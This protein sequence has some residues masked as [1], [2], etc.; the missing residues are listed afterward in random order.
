MSPYS[1]SE[2]LSQVQHESSFDTIDRTNA[3]RGERSS[4]QIDPRDFN[5]NNSI[6]V[7]QRQP[8][9]T[10][11]TPNLIDSEPPALDNETPA[12]QKKPV[13]LFMDDD[14]DN[15]SNDFNIFDD[16]NANSVAGKRPSNASHPNQAQKRSNERRKNP[17]NLFAEDDTD[18]FETMLPS[19]SK[20]VS[21]IMQRKVNSKITNLFEDD[22][23]D[24]NDDESD[25]FMKTAASTI[26]SNASL[27]KDVFMCNLFDDEPP[28]DDSDVFRT[29]SKPAAKAKVEDVRENQNPLN[30]DE[31]INSERVGSTKPKGRINLFDDQPPDDDFDVFKSSSKPAVDVIAKNF[32]A[33]DP[34]VT[35]E[36]KVGTNI[37]KSIN[38]FDDE[39]PVDF[40]VFKS[41]ANTEKPKSKVIVKSSAPPEDDYGIFKSTSTMATTETK[42]TEPKLIAAVD[43]RVATKKAA[44]KV[45]SKI[46]LFDD[47]YDDDDI[48][49]G[50]T[51]LSSQPKPISNE[52]K[53]EPKSA[54][55]TKGLWDSDEEVPIE[56]KPSKSNV[57]IFT[58]PN[59]PYDV[60]RLFDDTP[61][62]DDEDLFASKPTK[63][64]AVTIISKARGEFYNDFL[65]TIVVKPDEASTKI[66]DLTIENEIRQEALAEEAPSKQVLPEQSISKKASTE[67]ESRMEHLAQENKPSAIAKKIDLLTKSA[68]SDESKSEIESAARP[69]PK[70]LSVG[71]IEINVAALLPGAKRTKTAEQH[72]EPGISSESEID[73]N[74]PHKPVEI[75][76]V[77]TSTTTT[78]S[79][80]N[81]DDTGR[82]TNL[83]RD[84]AKVVVNRRPS[85]RR[86]RQQQ[87]Q[88]TLDESESVDSVD[89][90]SE[91]SIPA[92]EVFEPKY[93]EEKDLVSKQ[94]NKL[95]QTKSLEEI[96]DDKLM[97][98]K[99][100]AEKIA[101]ELPPEVVQENVDT[102]P[103]LVDVEI[104]TEPLDDYVGATASYTL[105][106]ATVNTN[107][108]AETHESNVA[109]Q[110]TSKS[111]LDTSIFDDDLGNNDSDIFVKIPAKTKMAVPIKVTP[112]FIADLP[113]DLDPAD[114]STFS[115]KNNQNA[116]LLSKNAVDLFD[117]DDDDDFDNEHIFSSQ[118]S[119]ES[120]TQANG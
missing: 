86:G 65:E 83:N 30:V 102:E 88:K 68:K 112:A 12:A 22:D 56:V 53:E 85:T 40:D 71:K 97:V 31:D 15:N 89:N 50:M 55:K 18:D 90:Q 28:E 98:T 33:Q 108:S 7:K 58:K 109:S 47:D 76:D 81:V 115:V 66:E 75:S 44:T 19:S 52:I 49:K 62:D 8:N 110:E 24:D 117:D 93:E 11:V 32:R 119:S 54:S 60:N 46:N 70:K 25:L 14:D 48:F 84:R 118:Q 79:Q 120:K 69:Q 9:P 104:D 114:E 116:S 16:V 42:V 61:P 51:K 80:D 57:A 39:P 67:K 59:N 99:R 5:A 87:Y 37:I 45:I 13:N 72:T 111:F 73:S 107:E 1:S 4:Q 82:L 6:F 100:S 64:K 20:T 95:E 36:P 78:A 43:N 41:T 96:L 10:H 17:V 38:L 23:D 27:K 3:S 35:S 74:P 21:S 29:T 77:K 26:S 34:E 113:P 106:D 103:E 105:L 2:N 91:I 63:P 101:N 94:S 92:Y